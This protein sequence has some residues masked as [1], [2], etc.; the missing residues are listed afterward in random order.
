MLIFSFMWACTRQTSLT[1]ALVSRIFCSISRMTRYSKNTTLKLKVQHVFEPCVFSSSSKQKPV[2]CEWPKQLTACKMW[3]VY[4]KRNREMIGSNKSQAPRDTNLLFFQVVANSEIPVSWLTLR[5]ESRS[6]DINNQMPQ[7]NPTTQ[8]MNNTKTYNESTEEDYLFW[9]FAD[10]IY[11]KNYRTG[12]STYVAL[13]KPTY[14]FPAI[15]FKKFIICKRGTRKGKSNAKTTVPVK[16][17]IV[18]FW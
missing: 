13:L 18:I 12:S 16:K 11:D 7:S 9:L 4:V 17:C 14:S 5:L 1:I 3:R 15:F 2:L 6:V 10:R 8:I